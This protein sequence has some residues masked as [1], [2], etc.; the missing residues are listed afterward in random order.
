MSF[1]LYFCGPPGTQLDLSRVKQKMGRQEYTTQSRSNDGRLIQFDYDNPE[2]GVYCLFDLFTPEDEEEESLALPDSFVTTGMSVSINFLRPHFFAL[3]LMPII[4]RLADSFGL[5]L[6]DSQED[7]IYAPNTPSETLIQSWIEHNQRATQAMATTDEPIRKPYLPREQS[8]Y[9][10]QYTNARKALQAS[11]G[12]DVFVP[13]IF[14]MA[15]SSERV[16]PVVL[17]SAGVQRRFLHRTRRIPLSQLFPKC[18]YL[19]LA[20]EKHAE[21]MEKG[22]VPYSTAVSAMA[23]FLEDFDGPV[24]EIKVLWPARQQQAS[25]IFEGLP[26]TALGELTRIAP[27]G[28]VDV[29]VS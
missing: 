11:L 14:L 8:L 4:S 2:T 13:A 25:A 1:D 27:D 12:E 10:W 23:A 22:I 18:E 29:V 24:E 7:R 17:W 6:Y 15:D 9:W 21:E 19:M 16:K 26:L 28:F 3:E 20:W 5:S